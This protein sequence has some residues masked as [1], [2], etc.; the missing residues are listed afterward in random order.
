[1]PVYPHRMSVILQPLPKDLRDHVVSHFNLVTDGWCWEEKAVKLA[2]AAWTL[3]PNLTVEVGVFGGKSFIPMA[4]VVAHLDQNQGNHQ[5]I[6]I[7][8][9]EAAAAVDTNEGTAHENYW[10][11][12]AM[13]D[14]VYSRA[15]A[16]CN[17]LGS[18][19]LKLIK[20]RSH[21]SVD[22]F[23]DGQIGLFSLDSNHSEFHSMRDATLWIPKVQIGGII[24]FDDTAWPSQKKAVEFFKSRCSIVWEYESGGNSC[25]FFRREA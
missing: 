10:K 14:G 19:A 20:A 22:Q 3:R 6:G 2:E 25:I 15:S 23:R 17:A 7:D 4:A 24:A 9:W 21:E 12:Q 5:A 16:R 1:M 13:L 18:R 8:A 11:D